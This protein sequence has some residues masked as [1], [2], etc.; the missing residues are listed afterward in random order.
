MLSP[1][2][3][4]TRCS[5]TT[6]G[7]TAAT[8]PSRR[9]DPR[10][11]CHLRLHRA[12]TACPR[13]PGSDAGPR[14]PRSASTRMSS[15]TTYR[16]TSHCWLHSPARSQWS[17]TSTGACAATAAP[18]CTTRVA[19]ASIKAMPCHQKLCTCTAVRRLVEQPRGTVAIGLLHQTERVTG[20]RTRC[21]IS[22][23]AGH[24]HRLRSG[25]PASHE[26]RHTAWLTVRRTASAPTWS[27][28]PGHE[29]K[30]PRPP[31]TAA[32]SRCHPRTGRRPRGRRRVGAPGGFP[33]ARSA[34]RS[35]GR[36]VQ[37]PTAG[38]RGR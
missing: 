27:G 31:S 25:R 35:L 13:R 37:M 33:P 28:R 21:R 29:R 38:S 24:V 14:P 3:R 19:A 34:R 32:R 15:P 7:S 16:R 10:R 8:R 36:L 20:Q 1:L 12:A 11:P 18:P 26:L 9:W 5:V 17:S 22:G 6:A 30:S 2:R 4:A 23:R